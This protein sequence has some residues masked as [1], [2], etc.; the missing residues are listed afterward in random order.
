MLSMSVTWVLCVLIVSGYQ[1]VAGEIQGP[2][3]GNCVSRTGKHAVHV[4]ACV[5]FPSGL[6]SLWQSGQDL[7]CVKCRSIAVI[8]AWVLRMLFEDISLDCSFD[9]LKEVDILGKI[10]FITLW[11]WFCFKYPLFTSFKK[12]F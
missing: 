10:I 5:F 2:A 3:E 12:K 4:S 6:I 11:I 8:K 7:N 9:C 1:G